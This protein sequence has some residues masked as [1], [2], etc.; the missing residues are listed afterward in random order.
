MACSIATSACVM[1]FVYCW[2][3][4]KLLLMTHTVRS[5]SDLAS[6]GVFSLFWRLWGDADG[7]VTEGLTLLAQSVSRVTSGGFPVTPT[8]PFGPSTSNTDTNGSSAA[9][10]TLIGTVGS[11][12]IYLSCQMSTAPQSMQRINS[13][14]GITQSINT[15]SREDRTAPICLYNKT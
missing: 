2:S 5:W 7:L 13:A 1:R 4:G 12:R 6:R 10:V 9:H 15:P 3:S 11:V 8:D 14:L